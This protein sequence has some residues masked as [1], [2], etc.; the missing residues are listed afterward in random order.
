LLV[1]CANE[2]L[3]AAGRTLHFDVGPKG[4]VERS[5]VAQNL[6]DAGSEAVDCLFDACLVGAL[7]KGR[8][9]NGCW[10]R[11]ESRAGFSLKVKACSTCGFSS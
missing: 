4:E 3:G 5:W 2:A 10:Y 7:V 9:T 8:S 11:G 1:E 6:N